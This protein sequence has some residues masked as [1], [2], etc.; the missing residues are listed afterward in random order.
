M[1]DHFILTIL[2]VRTA[3]VQQDL[4]SLLAMKY[5]KDKS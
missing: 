3:A 4:L 5:S 1:A 2:I